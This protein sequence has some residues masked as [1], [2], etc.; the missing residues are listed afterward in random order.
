MTINAIVGQGS[1][2]PPYAVGCLA[3]FADGATSDRV[4]MMYAD[5]VSEDLNHVLI[6]ANGDGGNE[7]EVVDAVTCNR[8]SCRFGTGTL[9]HY[10][11]ENGTTVTYGQIETAVGTIDQLSDVDF[12]QQN[13]YQPPVEVA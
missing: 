2:T 8:I 6:D 4:H 13:Y 12:S 7:A 3:P 1:T 11:Y 5:A 9:L 10:V